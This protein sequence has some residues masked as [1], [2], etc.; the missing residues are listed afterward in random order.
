MKTILVFHPFNQERRELEVTTITKT[1]VTL[2][3]PMA[4][5]YDLNLKENILTARSLGARRRNPCLW[6]AVDILAVREAI[7]VYMKKQ[8]IKE[9]VKIAK[10]KHEA[11]MPSYPYAKRR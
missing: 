10:T 5:A 8:D 6:K 1:Y 7:S 9:I 4:G 11:S 2:H 3:W